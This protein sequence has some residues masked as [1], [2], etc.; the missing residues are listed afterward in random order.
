MEENP[1]RGPN[2]GDVGGES[3]P[4]SRISSI[5]KLLTILGIIAIAI[6]FMLPAMRTSRPAA[7]RNACMNSLKQIALALQSY[8]NTYHAFPPAYTTDADG[9]PLHSWRTLILPYI[10][11]EQLYESIDLAKP[12]DDPA[13]AEA[14]KTRV[15]AYQ[16]PAAPEDDNQTTYLA[17]LTPNSCFRATEPRSLSEVT[18]GE[19]ETMMLIEVDSEHATPWMSPVDADEK[20]VL[21]IGP[22]SKL[23]HAGGTHAAFVDGTVRFLSDEMSS[24]QR[25]ELISIAGNESVSTD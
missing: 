7:R 3:K 16:C 8:E 4:K 23:A 2:S 6:A 24:S 13:N 21:G 15:M 5:L 12:W 22:K 14:C 25:R 19:S 18:D 17:I 9:K 10:E 1:Y 11:E 20:L